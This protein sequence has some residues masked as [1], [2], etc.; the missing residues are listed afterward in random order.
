MCLIDRNDRTRAR[1]LTA[2]GCACLAIALSNHA[3][4]GATTSAT[5]RAW[6]G[7]LTGLLLGV[8]IALNLYAVLLRKR[9]NH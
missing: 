3:L 5:A 7:G 9:A 2:I 6:I 1:R 4:A 8:S